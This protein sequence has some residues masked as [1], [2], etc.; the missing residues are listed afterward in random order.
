[1]R[2]ASRGAPMQ[3]DL[4]AERAKTLDHAKGVLANAKNANRDLTDDEQDQLKSDMARVEELD[5]GLKG[6]AMADKVKALWTGDGYGDG[7]DAVFSDEA[8]AGIA[9]AV[10]TRTAYRT[11]VDAKALLT[12]GTVLP[13]SGT[14]VQAGLH[15]SAY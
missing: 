1:M 15:P 5:R 12:T 13:T 3:T 4:R 14:V 11:N 6:R 2:R 7:S 9:Y 10:K 8:K